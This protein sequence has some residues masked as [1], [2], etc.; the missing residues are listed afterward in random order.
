MQPPHS[1]CYRVSLIKKDFFKEESRGPRN[2]HT[3]ASRPCF[4]QTDWH[5]KQCNNDVKLES[6]LTLK[7]RKIN[8]KYNQVFISHSIL[9]FKNHNDILTENKE[10][11]AQVWAKIK[12]RIDKKH[13][14]PLLNITVITFKGTAVLY[15]KENMKEGWVNTEKKIFVLWQLC[16]KGSAMDLLRRASLIYPEHSAIRTIVIFDGI[17]YLCFNSG[18]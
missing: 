8:W 9:L 1:L 14:S 11:E 10:K 7:C 13:W 12:A 4:K 17:S 3:Q 2:N 5:F 16:I 6:K 15:Q 18:I